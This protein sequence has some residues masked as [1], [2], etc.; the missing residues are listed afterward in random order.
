[1]ETSPDTVPPS[2]D[3]TQGVPTTVKWILTS[4][5]Q[6]ERSPRTGLMGHV[7]VDILRITGHGTDGEAVWLTAERCA[8]SRTL[9]GAIAIVKE[10]LGTTNKEDK[11]TL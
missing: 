5:T 4:G 1:M 10:E 7:G 8:W 9:A 3:H 2:P 6:R 11:K